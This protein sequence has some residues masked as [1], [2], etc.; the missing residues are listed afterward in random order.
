MKTLFL[1]VEHT[2]IF[3]FISRYSSTIEFNLH[4]TSDMASK[5][6]D[7]NNKQ[8]RQR[9][10]DVEADPSRKL[11]PIQGYADIPLVSLR[12]AVEPLVSIVH[13]VKR[14]AQCA[15][16]KS[17]DPPAD[18]LTLD[19][20]ASIRLY[21][22]DW[23]PQ[24]KSLYVVLNVTLRNENR[25]NLKP[26]FLYIKLLLTGLAGLQ[27]IPRI[28]FRGIKGDLRNDYKTGNKIIWW[29]FSSCT[30]SMN[31]LSNPMFLG[32]TG[33]R[34]LFT[35]EC[36]S[37][38]D[39]Q[40]HSNFQEEDE[41]LLPAARQFEVVSCLSQGPDLLLVHLQET[42]GPFSLIDLVPEVSTYEFLPSY[43]TDILV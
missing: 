12:E 30:R 10:L 31:V 28:V 42:K 8:H 11:S 4:L 13:D 21:S 9:Y 37:G 33:V 36:Q 27:S 41:I 34:T 16:W 6:N 18:N 15:I 38:R 29:G 40:Q 25:Q 17:K 2:F 23:E 14:M 22:M 20:S 19:Q 3:F 39:I 7:N 32:S 43:Y 5:Y 35:I 24:E 26:W 1:T